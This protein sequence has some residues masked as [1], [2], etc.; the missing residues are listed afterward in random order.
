[1]HL[2]TSRECFNHKFHLKSNQ[3]EFRRLS[4]KADVD[5]FICSLDSLLLRPSSVMV[6]KSSARR[7]AWRRRSYSLQKKVRTEVYDNHN[8]NA[9]RP[10][11][12][13]VYLTVTP[14]IAD[15][16]DGDSWREAAAKADIGEFNFDKSDRLFRIHICCILYYISHIRTL[17]SHRLHWRL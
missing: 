5:S 1:M 16:K 2:V 4:N 6:M 3:H 11:N 8:T 17:N 14:L 13:C 10:S 7:G 15:P 9:Y 12:S